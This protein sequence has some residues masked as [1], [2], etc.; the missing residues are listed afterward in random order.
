MWAAYPYEGAGQWPSL[1]IKR[2]DI[3]VLADLWR[4]GGSQQDFATAPRGHS[5]RIQLSNGRVLKSFRTNR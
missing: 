2:E 1:V 3:D 4:N 5:S